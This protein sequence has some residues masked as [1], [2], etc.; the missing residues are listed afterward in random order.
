MTPQKSTVPMATKTTVKYMFKFSD[1]GVHGEMEVYISS[2]L[3]P[4]LVSETQSL[5]RVKNMPLYLRW[6]A[7]CIEQ[8][9]ESA[10]HEFPQ[11]ED[12]F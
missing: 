11:K 5:S 6:K 4:T 2:A 10:K 8:A 3:M 12:P 7:H 9:I 1:M